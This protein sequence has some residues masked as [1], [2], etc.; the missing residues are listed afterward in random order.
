VVEQN[1]VTCPLVRTSYPPHGWPTTSVW[2]MPLSWHQTGDSGGYWQ[3]AEGIYALNMC[4]PST[5]NDVFLVL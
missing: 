1:S 3:Q 2:K 4:K 5:D